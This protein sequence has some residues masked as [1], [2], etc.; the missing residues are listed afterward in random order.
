MSRPQAFIHGMGHYHPNTVLNNDFFDELDIGSDA[1]WV[2][3][4]TGIRSR[5]SVLTVSDLIAMK[6]QR[7]T[8]TELRAQGR[9]QSI[10]DIAELAW[11]NLQENTKHS[12]ADP[13]LVICGTS[14]PDYAIPA[15]ACTISQ[16]LGFPSASFD[17]NSA[18]SSFVVNMH[19][20]RGLVHS[21]LN[22]KIA[23][24]N[25]ER[26]SLRID[27][28]DKNSCVLFGDGSACSYL[29]HEPKPGSLKVVDTFIASDPEGYELV[30]IP[31]D[32]YFSQNGR[33]VQKFAITRTIEATRA[34]MDRNQLGPDDIH[35]FAGHQANLRMITSAT[36]RLG[37][38]PDKHIFNVDEYGNQGA[39]GAPAVLSMNWNRF[40][41]GD[42]IIVTVVGSG[43][44]WGAALLEKT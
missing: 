38:D 27:F 16:R 1:Q 36:E 23:I 14:V 32:G 15:N 33:A 34:I 13:D 19:L 35:Y 17:A 25:P 9:V 42:R 7:T 41:T 5:R 39:A 37:F 18:C 10:A 12:F 31:D 44:T 2:E 11:K 28:R 29:S 22:Q 30:Q 24:F 21:G 43:L 4:R 20:A 6:E 40:K 26:Y 3:D 8:L